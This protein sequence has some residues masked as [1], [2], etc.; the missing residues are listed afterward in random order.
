VQFK[1]LRLFRVLFSSGFGVGVG[2]LR[3]FKGFKLGDLG[4]V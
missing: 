1:V 2:V 3:E 4:W